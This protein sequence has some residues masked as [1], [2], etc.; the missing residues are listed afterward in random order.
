MVVML[1]LLTVPAMAAPDTITKNMKSTSEILWLTK[2]EAE[3]STFSTSCIISGVAS[4][5]TNITIYIKDENTKDTYRKMII[6]DEELS[7]SVGASGMFI[8][9][10]SLQPNIV[11]DI[12]VYAEQDENNYQVEKRTITVKDDSIKEAL[13]NGAIMIEDFITKIFNK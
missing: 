13:K 7:W 3:V 5:N 12:I 4:P 11:N 8:K 6:D 10:I 2:P 1:G 9:E